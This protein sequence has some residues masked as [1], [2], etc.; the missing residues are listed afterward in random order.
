MASPAAQI[1]IGNAATPMTARMAKGVAAA[2]RHGRGPSPPWTSTTSPGPCSTWPTLPPDAN[3]L[4]MT[5]MATEMP[6][7]GRG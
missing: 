7:L 1:D 2:R 5:I 4:S 6:F 3:V